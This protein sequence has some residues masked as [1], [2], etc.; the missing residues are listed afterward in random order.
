[1]GKGISLWIGDCLERMRDIPDGSVDM[2]LTDPPYGMT[3]ARWDVP[4]P[5]G[6]LWEQLERVVKPDGA[7]LIF[8][9]QPFTSRLVM[10]N[11]EMFR[12]EWIWHKTHPKGHLNAKRMPMRAHENIEVFYR[13]QPTY[14]PQMT[15]GHRRKVARTVYEREPDG[16]SCYGKESRDTFYDSTD[17]YP[18]SVQ[19]FSKGNQRGKLNQTQKPVE[20]F[21]YFIRTYTDEGETVLDPF[22][23]SMVAAIAAIKAGRKAVCIEKDE[24]M[25]RAGKERVKDFMKGWRDSDG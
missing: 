3:Q 8:S 6:P 23:G 16:S 19:T 18:L 4:V 5:F 7:I 15:H 11:L 21:E 17:R 10:S 20:L 12:Y 9:L 14:N 1:M 24:E 22:A 13:K 2:V 25:F